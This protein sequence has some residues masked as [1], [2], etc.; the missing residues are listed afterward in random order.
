MGFSAVIHL[1]SLVRLKLALG[2]V[3]DRATCRCPIDQPFQVSCLFQMLMR[4]LLLFGALFNVEN[5]RAC[6]D[7]SLCAWTE[8]QYPPKVEGRNLC[9]A[10]FKY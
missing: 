1:A 2:L 10:G 5:N 6:I 7:E 9:A 3:V 8:G 4:Q